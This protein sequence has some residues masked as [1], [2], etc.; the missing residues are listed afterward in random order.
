MNR[1]H[2]VGR[3]NHGKTTLIVELLEEFRRRGVSVGSVK[4]S[5]HRHELDPPGK[6]SYRH[7]AAGA[8]PAAIVSRNLVGVFVR[9]DEITDCYAVIGPLFSG[10]KLVLVEGDIDARAPK[11]EVWRACRGTPCLATERDDILAVVSD[12]SPPVSLPVWPRGDIAH[13]ADRLLAGLSP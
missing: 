5:A 6:D 2:I 10:C 9:R 3:K 4:H 8:N 12:D 7:R 1:I 13:L 11:I